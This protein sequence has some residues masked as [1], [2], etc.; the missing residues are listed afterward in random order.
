[1]HIHR[2]YWTCHLLQAVTCK[3]DTAADLI[4]NRIDR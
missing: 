2:A 4:L 3:A 1:V